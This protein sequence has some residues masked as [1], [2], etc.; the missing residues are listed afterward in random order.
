MVSCAQRSKRWSI[1]GK[2]FD[3]YKVATVANSQSTM[4]KL[5]TTPITID[6]FSIDEEV[7]STIIDTYHVPTFGTGEF[8]VIDFINDI[9]YNCEKLRKKYVETG[10]KAYWRALVQ[11]LPMSWN[12]TRTWTGNYQNLR[13]MYSTRKN[14]KLSEWHEFC[15]MIECLPYGKELICYQRIGA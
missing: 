4:H 12:Q 9:I 1:K 8:P 11:T 10:D 6:C 15:N 13:S 3:T 5:A 14:H 7:K 2:E